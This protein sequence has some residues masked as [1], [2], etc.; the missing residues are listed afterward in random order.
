MKLHDILIR[1]NVMNQYKDPDSDKIDEL[2]E[3]VDLSS[4]DLE[5][6]EVKYF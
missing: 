2:L 3:S 6:C 4:Y 1:T 5:Q